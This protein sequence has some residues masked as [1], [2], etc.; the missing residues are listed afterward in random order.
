MMELRTLTTPNWKGFT[1]SEAFKQDFLHDVLPEYLQTCRWFG[2]KSAAIRRF[3]AELIIPLIHGDLLYYLTILEV[4]FESAH[5]ENYLLVLTASNDESI[6]DQARIAKLSI[7]K[8][9]TY[10]VDGLYDVK[11]REYLFYNIVNTSSVPHEDGQLTFRKGQMLQNVTADDLVSSKALNAEQSNTTIVFND[12]YYLKVYRKLFRDANP[13]YELTYF[14][15]ERTQFQNSPRFAGSINWMRNAFEI[16][17]GLM[18]EKVENKG[19]AWTYMLSEVR[20]FFNRLV[21]EKFDAKKLDEIALYNRLK[22]YQLSSDTAHLIGED[23]IKRIQLLALRTAEMHLALFKEKFTRRFIPKSFNTDY[24]AWLLNR[25]IY[26]VDHRINLME[27]SM[28]KLS[29]E[30]KEYA[31]EFLSLKGKIKDRIL[32]FHSSELNSMRIRIHGDYHLGQVILTDD[33]FYI[34]DF[35][36]EPEATIRDRK[37]KQPPLKDVAGMLRSFQYA[38]YANIFDKS[39]PSPL[40]KE[41]QF[42]AGER[43]YALIVGLFMDTYISTSFERGLDIGYEKEIEFLLKYHLLEKAIYE[44]GYELNSRPDWVIIPLKG[45]LDIINEDHGK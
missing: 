35:E 20:Q 29:D 6:P 25:L 27:N 15:S 14:L 45:V 24:K 26:H 44:L 31:E 21:E 22:D 13:D 38:I 30:A 2:S 34:L 19:D 42:I 8:S 37:V 40:S 4:I 39:N 17:I 5:S 32:N 16:T 43:Y 18:Q 1:S 7:G 23:T 28:H 11:F 41:D 3:D 36:G 33:D 12:T 9:Q 10:L